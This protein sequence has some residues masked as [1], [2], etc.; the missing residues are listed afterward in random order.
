MK[1]KFIFFILLFSFIF[2][3]LH[4]TII[5]IESDDNCPI[6]VQIMEETMPNT[7][8]SDISSFHHFFHLLAIFNDFDLISIKKNIQQIPHN[9]NLKHFYIK[10]PLLRP[11]IV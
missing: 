10:N 3:I 9:S 1:Y 8:C 4:D 11:P 6:V 7:S 2:N 5:S